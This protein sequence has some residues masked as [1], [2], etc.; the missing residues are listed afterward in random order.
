MLQMPCALKLFLTVSCALLGPAVAAATTSGKPDKAATLTAIEGGSGLVDLRLSAS[1]TALF[2]A[3]VTGLAIGDGDGTAVPFSVDP[4]DPVV[5][6]RLAGA[7]AV[8]IT[9]DPDGASPVVLPAVPVDAAPE[10]PVPS[11]AMGRVWYQVFP[12]RYRNG[13]PRNDPTGPTTYRVPWNAAWDR[14]T[15]DELEA[16]WNH[17]ASSRFRFDRDQLGGSLYHVVW[18]RR[19]GGDLQGVVETLP[20]LKALGVD[21]IYLTPIFAASSMH[22]YDTADYRHIDPTFGNPG[23]VSDADVP[24]EAQTADPATWGWTTA[25]RYFIDEFLPACRAAGMRVMIDVSWN[26]TGRDFWAFDHVVRHGEESPYAD[27][28]EVTFDDAGNIDQWNAWDRPNGY[29]PRFKRTATGDLHPDVKQHIFD[30]TSRWM[31]PNGDGDPSDGVD[32]WR[33]D[34]AAEIAMPFWVDWRAHVKRINPDALLV[35]EIWDDARSF[36]GGRAFDAQMNYPFSYP[37]VRWLGTDP[38]M[39]S[40]ELA[41]ELDRVFTQHPAIDLAQMTILDSHDTARIASMLLNPGRGGYDTNAQPHTENGQGYRRARPPAEIYGRVVMGVA[42]QSLFAGSP[43][44]Y[45]GTEWGMHGAD[46]PDNRKPTPWPDLGAPEDPDDVPQPN[47]RDRVAAWLALRHD[48]ALGDVLRVGRVRTLRTG[49]PGVFAFV[50][51]LDGVTVLAV[52]N[53]GPR[54]YAGAQDVIA[55]LGLSVGGRLENITP[56][57]EPI[58]D[59]D[60]VLPGAVGAWMWSAG[61]TGRE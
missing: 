15:P 54:P 24:S 60:V 36:F 32:G 10:H 37:V 59:I 49:E 35:A 1:A 34:V 40:D 41:D 46:D 7:D 22:K 57:T 48:E 39:T 44:V 28:F 21:G 6:L 61:T 25:D 58:A 14:V 53:R 56:D 38:A 42:I 27:W 17:G 51:Q 52:A 16:G 5:R 20:H 3:P 23:S 11:W 43:M 47:V 33:L 12:E 9:L 30:V 13:S 26:H 8:R 18:H 19:Y 4:A 31:D 29:L 2:D 55:R 50:R 45:Y